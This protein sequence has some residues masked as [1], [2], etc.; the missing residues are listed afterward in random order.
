MADPTIKQAQ[1]HSKK[2]AALATRERLKRPFLGA[3][4][5]TDLPGFGKLTEEEI[6]DI[7]KKGKG[8]RD[9]TLR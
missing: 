1:E 6:L 4:A 2:M 3:G 7:R 9:F 5:V 8:L